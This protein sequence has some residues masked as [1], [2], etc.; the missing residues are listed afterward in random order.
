VPTAHD[1]AAY[2]RH[3]ETCRA[4]KANQK[5]INAVHL[6]PG[7]RVRLLKRIGTVSAPNDGERIDITFEDGSIGFC[8]KWDLTEVDGSALKADRRPGKRGSKPIDVQS[9]VV[10][11]IP[12]QV[13][14]TT[15]VSKYLAPFPTTALGNAERLVARF[16]SNIRYCHPWKRWLIWDGKRW[17][18]DDTGA[19]VRHATITVRLIY[20]EASTLDDGADRYELAKWART[21]ESK[22][23]I[24]AT[25][26][27]AQSRKGIPLLP[28]AMD[29]DLWSFNC[30]NGTINLHTGE[31]QSQRRGDLITKISPVTYDPAATCPLW[32]GTLEVFIPDVEVRAYIKRLC[33]KALVGVI[34]E[35]QLVIAWGVGSIGK[36]TLLNTLLELFGEDYAIKAD[37][38]S[39]MAKRNPGHSTERMDFFGKR[40][41]VAIETEDGKGINESLIKEL[42]GGDYIRGRRMREDT[43]QYKPTHTLIMAS[44]YKRIIRGSSHGFG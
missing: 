17:N 3:L 30:H 33:G 12:A 42:T 16:G 2:E 39:L 25:I 23:N 41:V 20:E 7:H 28:C 22:A 38:D 1:D 40:L 11:T 34:R 27:L 43:W 5:E 19:I 8:G 21:S 10:N 35:H 26:Q 32:E 6:E 9:S 31:L 44:N 4:Q 14:R 15:D 18:P 29:N 24:D 37:A 13:A 36:S